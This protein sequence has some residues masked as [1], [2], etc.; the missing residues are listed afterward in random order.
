LESIKDAPCVTGEKSAISPCVTAFG[1]YSFG[2]YSFVIFNNSAPFGC[3]IMIYKSAFQRLKG[4][5]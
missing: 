4:V 2:G 5:K 3:R 1:G